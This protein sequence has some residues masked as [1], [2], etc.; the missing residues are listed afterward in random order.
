MY[1]IKVIKITIY[2][3]VIA[4]WTIFNLYVLKKVQT[5]PRGVMCSFLGR[6]M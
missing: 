3:A 5:F 2:A 6:T 4:Y 1:L